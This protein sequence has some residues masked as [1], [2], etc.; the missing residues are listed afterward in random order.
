VHGGLHQQ[1]ITKWLLISQAPDLNNLAG[2]TPGRQPALNNHAAM[3]E[4][5]LAHPSKRE[6]RE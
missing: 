6:R 4:S 3:I 1:I 5:M 2:L